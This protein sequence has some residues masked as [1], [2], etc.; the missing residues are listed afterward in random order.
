MKEFYK[1]KLLAELSKHV[2]KG[3]AIDMGEL[4]ERVFGRYCSDKHNK[5]RKIRELITELRREGLPIV[6]D[7]DK[8]G[9]GYYLAAAGKELEEYCKRLRK[10]AL[11]IL[12]IEAKLRNTTLPAILAQIIA[13]LG[14]KEESH[15]ESNA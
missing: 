3:K 14:K 4:Y 5:A 8:E 2:G 6:S 13:S 10:R 15:V 7:H 1:A 11:K 9:G 12:D